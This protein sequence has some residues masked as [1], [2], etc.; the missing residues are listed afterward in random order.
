[1]K[2]SKKQVNT[3]GKELQAAIKEVAEKHNL[4]VD[5]GKFRYDEHGFDARFKLR[6]VTDDGIRTEDR[7]GWEVYA[8]M[9][10]V[11]KWNVGDSFRLPNFYQ[12]FTIV[13]WNPRSQKQPVL[14]KGDDGLEYQVAPH[15]LN[16]GQKIEEII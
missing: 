3:I 4:A 2:L 7:E 16:H 5:A 15:V 13:G 14:L 9:N 6:V 1:M 10:G 11:K 12:T 8:P